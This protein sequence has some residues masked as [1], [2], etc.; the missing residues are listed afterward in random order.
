MLRRAMNS[1]HGHEG[2]L[3]WNP[4]SSRFQH[5]SSLC[6]AGAAI[7]AD[8]A[9]ELSLLPPS[10]V[11]QPIREESAPAVPSGGV[12]SPE[13]ESFK[14]QKTTCPEPEVPAI[15]SREP[16][17]AGRTSSEA[18]WPLVL[19]ATDEPRVSPAAESLS[20][21]VDQKHA[22]FAR[23]LAGDEADLSDRAHD[24][25]DGDATQCDDSSPRASLFSSQWWASG[26]I[27]RN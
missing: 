24:A 25:S 16:A 22:R 7:T 4:A 5:D 20:S 3:V 17:D 11:E 1:L 9:S 13:N 19:P 23:L 15:E 18:D 21:N 8:S 12:S 14:P 2:C 10:T 26:K 27:P 6:S